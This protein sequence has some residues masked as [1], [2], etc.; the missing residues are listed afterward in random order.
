MKVPKPLPKQ[1]SFYSKAKK[2]TTPMTSPEEKKF[3][4]LQ[5]NTASVLALDKE[6]ENYGV[7]D[8]IK[9]R[10][11]KNNFIKTKSSIK[12][13]IFYEAI[14]VDT[15]SIDIEH[16]RKE[17][18]DFISYSKIVIK[19]IWTPFEWKTDHLHTP[20]PLSMKHKPQMYTWYDYVDARFNF[21]YL[22]PRHTWFVKY[23]DELR[24]KIIPGW[25]YKWWN[26]FGENMSSLFEITTL[27]EYI[28]MCKFFITKR[29]S[30][31]ISWSFDIKEF[32]RI[33][34][35]S[36]VIYVKGWSPKPKE[37]KPQRI[38]KQELKKTLLQA[39]SNLEDGEEPVKIMELITDS[40]SKDDNGD[41]LNLKG[42]AQAYFGN[43][44][45]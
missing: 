2:E 14:L 26:T 5:R 44:D 40:K 38:A 32:D 1:Q 7:E 20:I 8:L 43:Y 33:R 24:T 12:T 28:R 23:G 27:P 31:I 36:K 16:I 29:I 17:G 39:I 4:F 10:Y 21:L 9:P 35:L 19:R 37:S 42:L 11:T 6:Y 13:R 34:F 18:S 25:F 3:E 15:K 30:Y 22:R 41:M 45:D